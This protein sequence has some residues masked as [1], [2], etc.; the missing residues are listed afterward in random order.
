MCNKVTKNLFTLGENMKYYF[1]KFLLLFVYLISSG[2]IATGAL[3]FEGAEW[4]KLVFL[5][6]N[7]ALFIFIYCAI[8]FKDGEKA[9]KVRVSND[10]IREIIVKT[11][12]DYP[13]NL[14]GEFTIRKGFITG[15]TACLPLVFL[16]LL[17][18]L[19][20][21]GSTNI[22]LNSLQLLYMAF[23][24]FFNLDFLGVHSTVLYA[25]PYWVLI[26]IPVLVILHGVLFY[27]GGR[28]A[29]L[30]QERIKNVHMAYHGK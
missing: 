11:G 15:A 17:H 13:L 10:K 22:A 21:N 3:A 27:L 24:G 26:S 16:L 12:E 28:R 7:L 30:Q 6:L 2:I 25:S 1:K 9:L 5:I 20:G 19:F 18:L 23:Y 14:Q 29:E 4:I 8:A